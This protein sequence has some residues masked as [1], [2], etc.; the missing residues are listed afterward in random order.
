[1]SGYTRPTGESKEQFWGRYVGRLFHIRSVRSW[2]HR[3]AIRVGFQLGSPGQ[4]RLIILL[5][6]TIS[7]D[8]LLQHAVDGFCKETK[9]FIR[10]FPLE[11]DSTL[12]WEKDMCCPLVELHLN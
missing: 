6:R 4:F 8:H 1:M 12:A 9:V 2:R 10:L 3:Q 7:I 11:L 5:R